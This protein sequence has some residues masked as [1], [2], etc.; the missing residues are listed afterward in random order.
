MLVALICNFGDTQYTYCQNVMET[1]FCLISVRILILVKFF[2]AV[3][4]FHV[5]GFLQVIEYW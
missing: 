4:I 3:L 1:V 5:N 2:F